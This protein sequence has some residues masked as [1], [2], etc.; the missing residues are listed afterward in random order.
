VTSS[1]LSTNTLQ[2]VAGAHI[3]VKAACPGATARKPRS[4]HPAA[5]SLAEGSR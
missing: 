3:G 1:W 5:V 4:A 2:M